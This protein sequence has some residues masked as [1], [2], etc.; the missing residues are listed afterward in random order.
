MYARGVTLRTGL[1]NARAT[2]PSVLSLIQAGRL[3][4]ERITSRIAQ[5]DDAAEALLDPSAK[6]VVVR[7]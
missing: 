6:V 7:D 4:P 5:W 2:I 1:I 3:Q